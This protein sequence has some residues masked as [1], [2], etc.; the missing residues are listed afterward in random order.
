MSADGLDDHAERFLTAARTHRECRGGRV[1]S[2]DDTAAFIELDINVEMPL[3]MRVDGISES[4]VRR[5]ETV[6]ARLGSRY[7]WSPPTFFL[8]EDFPRN[9]PHLQPGP[10]T[11]L[12]RPCL[13]DSNE[14]EFFI[15][16]GL[17]ELGVFN[18]VHQLV[19][20][21]RHAAEGTLI[22]PEQGWEPTLRRDLSAEVVI[23]AEACR[24]LVDRNGGHRVLKSRYLRSGAAGASIGAEAFAWID[25]TPEPTPLSR[26]DKKLF[27]HRAGQG[28]AEGNTVCAVVWPDKLP[29]GGLLVASSYMPETVTTYADLMARADELGC[30]RA[31]RVFVDGLERCFR[32]FVLDLPVPVAVILCARRPFHL[33]GSASDIEL[34]PYVIEI[35]APNGRASLFAGGEAEPVAPSIQRDSPNPALLRR[36]S[37]APELPPLA[38][39]G[40]GSVGSKMAMHLARSGVQISVVS[41]K[42]VLLPHNMARHAL[43]R[44][45]L[46]RSKAAE[47]AAELSQIGQSPQVHEDDLVFDLPV[48][49]KRRILLPRDAGCAVNTT[50]SLAVREALSALPATEVKPRLAEAALFGRGQG[51]LLFLDGAAHNPT[52]SDLT[53]EL[54]ATAGSPRLRALLF[55]SDHGLAEVQIGQGCSS[56][57]MPMTDMRLSAMTAG[58]TEQL[59]QEIQTPAGEG[60]IIVATT[61]ADSPD[62]NWF[63]QS[64]PPFTVVDVEGAEGWTLRITRRVLNQ[65]YAEVA[66]WPVA[67]TGGLMIGV[68]SARLRTVTV[69]DLLP[70]PPDS[71]RS[72]GRFALGTEGLEA[73]IKARH[74][75]SGST[76]FDVGTWHSHLNDQGP[77]E[78]DRKTAA[79]LAAER[80]PP[81]ALLIV[82]PARLF[83]LMHPRQGVTAVARGG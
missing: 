9:L 32:G 63:R 22:N 38:M 54:Y 47:L 57:T 8:R 29:D 23:D 69:V 59:V 18:L 62:T 40:C 81:S 21:L 13:V 75:E 55:D 28:Y 41:D 50:A 68:C 53:A 20:W 14:R 7:P 12:P 37:G 31:L 48:R 36:V 80:P 35:R 1:V 4:G 82:T 49:E 51:G 67:E 15:Q 2:A 74:V 61:A 79:E 34:L 76:L 19:L 44:P 3:H 11:E 60:R 46:A 58:L 42:S 83:G 39:L 33:I 6:I 10:L 65:I 72:A 71:R 66:R 25:V 27:T 24:A 78:L 64:V 56:L 43:A 52:L 16:F 45:P 26:D 73:A 30:G 77:S 70:A 5:T 17:V